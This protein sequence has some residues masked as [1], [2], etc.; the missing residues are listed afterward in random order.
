MI[1]FYIIKKEKLDMKISSE[2]KKIIEDIKALKIQGARNV[3]KAT[4]K[5]FTLFILNSEDKEGKLLV[6]K[7]IKFALELMNARPTEPMTRNMMKEIINYML[8]MVEKNKSVEEIKKAFE[9]GEEKI[10]KKFEESIE[11]ISS[12]GANYIEDDSTIITYCH[13]STVT[14]IL[15][16]AYDI[17]KNIKVYSCETRPRYQGRIT[18][19]ELSE[20]GIETVSIV[21]GAM[22]RFGKKA[23][24]ALV[25]AD[26]ITS[27]GDLINK[28]GTLSLA[29][30]MQ[31]YKKEFLSAAELYK[32]DPQTLLGLREKIEN[33]DPKEIWEYK[34]KNL[35]ILNPAFDYVEARYISKY[36]TEA[37]IIAPDDFRETFEKN[38]IL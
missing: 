3:A 25:G 37:G 11:K 13:S 17:G 15:K 2:I 14:S 36:I 24:L 33:R 28:I 9:E 1:G 22:A 21:D 10:L 23:D 27:S 34:G 18:A 19:K 12:I 6:E 32:Y 26:A 30:V 35:R 5:A 20:Y 31:H 8:N 38:R 4:I 29:I 7:S 16:K